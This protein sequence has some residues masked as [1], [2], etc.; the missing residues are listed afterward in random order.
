MMNFTNYHSLFANVFYRR[1]AERAETLR[2]EG[3]FT[4]FTVSASQHPQR[5]CDK[6]RQ[7][8]NVVGYGS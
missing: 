3:L 5:L 6:I 2:L 1:D 4:A 8:K 7:S